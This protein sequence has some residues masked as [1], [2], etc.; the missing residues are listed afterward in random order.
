VLVALGLVAAVAAVYQPVV[1]HEFVFLD[2]P[3]YVLEN[4]H[5]REGL[6]PASLLR[7]FFVTIRANWVPLTL[8]SYKIDHALWGLDAGGFLLSNAAL[9]AAS[10]VLLFLALARMTR[11][12]WPSA[13]VA[14]VFAVHPLHVESVAW[15]SERKDVLSGLFFMLTLLCYAAW[16]E[17]SDRPGRFQLA[18]VCLLLGLLAK[19]MLVTAPFV[20]LLLDYWPLGRLG[21][22]GPGLRARALEKLP[23]FAAVAALAAFALYTQRLV[24]AVAD[25]GT[26]PLW[27][28]AGNAA[29]AY[30]AYLAQS[31]W[32]SGLAVFYPHPREGVS[33]AASLACLALLLALS[34]GALRAGRARPW[35]AVGWAWYLGMLVPV[36]GLVQVGLQARADRYTYLPQTGLALALAF[37]AAELAGRSRRWRAGLALAG[38][39]AVLAL[40]GAARLQVA[41]WRSSEALFERALAVTRGN[42]FIEQAYGRLLL[43]A[44]RLDEAE[45]QL[46]RAA[47]H[48]PGWTLPRIELAD[49]AARRGA[50][51][52]AAAAYREVL[53]D[54]PDTPKAQAHLAF[55]LVELGRPEEARRPLAALA[56]RGEPPANVTSELELWLAAVRPAADAARLRREVARLLAGP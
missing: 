15:V 17:R 3:A 38:G 4:P 34:A 29:Q 14:A 19:P 8:L 11:A 18:L 35:L 36:I 31:V 46:R 53:R 50:L 51:E 21:R 25:T 23:M 16:T 32:P 40:A 43:R 39:A 44:G 54:S 1:S 41:H 37:S 26:V 42:Y 49:L 9:H 30:V 6:A 48:Y 45:R 7:S 20:L 12:L 28:R 47:E 10:S 56:A 33:A 22:G 2:D 55:V 52:A 13:F 24:G 27:A 5:V